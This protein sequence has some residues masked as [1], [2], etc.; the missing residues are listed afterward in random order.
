LRRKD[1]T[2]FFPLQGFLKETASFY[3]SLTI[4]EAATDF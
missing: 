4:Y 2:L 1:T 3:K